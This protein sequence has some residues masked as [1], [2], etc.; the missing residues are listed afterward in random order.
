MYTF[1]LALI[2]KINFIA[3]KIQGEHMIYNIDNEKEW[4]IYL[5]FYINF[6]SWTLILLFKDFKLGHCVEIK[7]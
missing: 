7:I 1:L 4:T 2:L 3:I 6:S 5:K